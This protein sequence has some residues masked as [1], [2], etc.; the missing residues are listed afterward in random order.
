[1]QSMSNELL[2]ALIGYNLLIYFLYMYM[3][4]HVRDKK[5]S[6]IQYYR[7]LEKNGN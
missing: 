7:N 4:L 6:A 1:M 2:V 3:C 5:L